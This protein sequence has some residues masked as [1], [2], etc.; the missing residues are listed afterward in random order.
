MCLFFKQEAGPRL[1]ALYSDAPQSGKS[2]IALTLA[3]ER[4][5]SVA[6]FA[7]PIK[8]LAWVF[9]SQFGMDHETIHA[10]LN[11]DLKEEP[12]LEDLP[13]IT[14]RYIMQTLGTEWGRD[15]ISSHLWATI[16]H[17]RINDLREQ[18]RNVVVDDLR[19]PNEYAM[20]AALGAKFIKIERPGYEPSDQHRSTGAL[21]DYPFHLT[22]RNDGSLDDLIQAA[23]NL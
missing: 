8:R 12:L 21:A 5:F 4:Q 9:L 11:G 6:S 3:E 13:G 7:T 20:L 18:G 17:K 14:P 2:T 15:L 22:L 16:M 19:F 10:A 1:L 23:R